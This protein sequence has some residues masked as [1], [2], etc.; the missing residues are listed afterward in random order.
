MGTYV[1]DF[2][3]TVLTY[4][5]ELRKYK[6]LSFAEERRLI[7]QYRNGNERA[8]NKIL[9]AHLKFVFDVAKKY[10]GRGLAMQDLISE[11]NMGLIKAFEKF[12]ESKGVKFIS[13]AVWWIR[14]SISEAIEK[15]GLIKTT[16]IEELPG[17]C[18]FCDRGI[19][20]VEDDDGDY[21][22]Q[23]SDET[24]V[25][26]D[27][28]ETEQKHTVS[29]LMEKLSDREKDVIE[30]YYGLN[31]KKVLTLFEIGVKYGITSERVRQ[32]KR[33]GFRKLRTEMML[34]GAG[35]DELLA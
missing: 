4:Y 17:D 6:P 26:L 18:H 34:V 31:G 1:N 21:T 11:G 25:E 5:K 20:D 33:Q 14:Q 13:Y 23:F 7:H 8:R 15:N 12:D 35:R 10:S 32:I 3:E 19:P 28:M 24:D 27:D 16:S 22:M 2:N 9:E 29:V 30:L